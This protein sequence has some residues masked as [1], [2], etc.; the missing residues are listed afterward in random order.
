MSDTPSDPT[1]R[2]RRAD[3]RREPATI[4]LSATEVRADPATAA[5]RADDT[6]ATPLEADHATEATRPTLIVFTSPINPLPSAIF[7]ATVASEPERCGDW[8]RYV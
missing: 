5:P 4:D 7:P 3:S 6:P 8:I 2:P 1:P